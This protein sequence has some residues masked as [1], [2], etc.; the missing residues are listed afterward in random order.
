MVSDRR[1]K[2]FAVIIKAPVRLTLNTFI[3]NTDPVIRKLG[4]RLVQAF[5]DEERERKQDRAA[6]AST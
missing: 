4:E 5:D 2:W 1:Q 6:D 3:S